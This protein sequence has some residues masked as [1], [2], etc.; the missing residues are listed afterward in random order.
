MLEWL[1][2]Q[3]LLRGSKVHWEGGRDAQDVCRNIAADL[4]MVDLMMTFMAGTAQNLDFA[5]KTLS[6][7]LEMT[8]SSD[9]IRVLSLVSNFHPGPRGHNIK[10]VMRLEVTEED[11]QQ[12]TDLAFSRLLLS[13]YRNQLFHLF[14]AEAMLALSVYHCLP[15]SRG[16][17]YM[18]IQFHCLVMTLIPTCVL[19]LLSVA[20][21]MKRFETLHCAL[22]REFVLPLCT[23]QEVSQRVL[24]CA[25]VNKL[26]LALYF[27]SSSLL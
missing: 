26:S 1:K 9:T 13:H 18:H 15:C 20:A 6:S 2:E 17:L 21:A 5:L 14:V 12:V 11:I 16:T 4:Y 24:G 3:V 23:P 27:S 10:E 25:G 7:S 8:S 22:A 19:C